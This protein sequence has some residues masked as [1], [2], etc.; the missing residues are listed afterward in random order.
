MDS[1][2]QKFLSDAESAGLSEGDYLKACN[3]LKQAFETAKTAPTPQPEEQRYS[4]RI[5]LSLEVNNHNEEEETSMF[6]FIFTFHE[7]LVTLGTHPNEMRVSYSI[8][9]DGATLQTV[10]ST[11]VRVPEAYKLLRRLITASQT[12]TVYVKTME[13]G[14]V[15]YG[16]EEVFKNDRARDKVMNNVMGYGDENDDDC[17]YTRA[18]F[19]NI[20][21][22]IVQEMIN[23]H[24]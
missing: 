24:Y 5:P 23:L 14:T 3:A 18:A 20:M 6:E 17:C 21:C 12:L 2:F 11:T 7:Y 19:G 16:M 4:R 15:W 1:L 22:D 8:H 13:T 9:K 10:E